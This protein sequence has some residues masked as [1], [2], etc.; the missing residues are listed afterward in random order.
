MVDFNFVFHKNPYPKHLSSN[1]PCNICALNDREKEYNHY[2]VSPEECKRCGK[3]FTWGTNC[4]GK[5]AE[6]ENKY[7]EEC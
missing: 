1:S 2:Y 3:Y 7:E 5:L 4:L 6:M